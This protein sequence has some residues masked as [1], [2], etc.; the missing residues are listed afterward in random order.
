MLE[1][2]KKIM[3]GI[4]TALFGLLLTLTV[5]L[6]VGRFVGVHVFTVLSGSMEPTYPTGSMIV[7]RPVKTEQLDTGDIIT[8]VVSDNTL[9][10]HRIAGIV[11]DETDPGVVRFRTKGDANNTEDML[12]VHQNN[13]VG[14][15]FFCIPYVGYV[16]NF[17]RRPPGIYVAVAGASLLVMLMFL[18]DLFAKDDEE[19]DDEKKEGPSDPPAEAENEAPAE[20]KSE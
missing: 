18:P 14:S 1:K 8:Y 17:I 16:V 9:V 12:L 19:E 6:T 4:C 20:E 2:L 3:S 15:P 5:L 13:V 7:V 11:P 10:T